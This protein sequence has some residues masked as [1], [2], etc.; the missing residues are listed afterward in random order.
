MTF[1]CREDL[2]PFGRP[3][4]S[5]HFSNLTARRTKVS[6]GLVGTEHVRALPT[7]RFV[8]LHK[9]RRERFPALNKS[10]VKSNQVERSV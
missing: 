2:L 7:A 3:F 10:D 9:S 4:F 1:D 6:D 5:S 8:H